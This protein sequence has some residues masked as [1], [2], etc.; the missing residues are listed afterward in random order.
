MTDAQK[1][2]SGLA[3]LI[4]GVGRLLAA[5]FTGW[6]LRCPE[7]RVVEQLVGLEVERGLNAAIYR[8]PVCGREDRLPEPVFPYEG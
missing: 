7:C 3:E 1:R 4:G 8:C 6:A 5:P 2:E